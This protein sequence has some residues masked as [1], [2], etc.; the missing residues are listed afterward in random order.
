MSGS[1]NAADAPGFAESGE[2]ASGTS[3]ATPA[4]NFANL[5]GDLA[6]LELRVFGAA[7]SEQ[8][9]IDRLDALERSIFG[10]AQTGSLAGRLA[11]LRTKLNT[12][13]KPSN[14]AP[15]TAG[16]TAGQVA[17][18]GTKIEIA[19]PSAPTKPRL[20][21]GRI[22]EL[23]SGRVPMLPHATTTQTQ[24]GKKLLQSFPNAFKGAW[25]GV[26]QVEQFDYAPSSDPGAV[27]VSQREQGLM[28]RGRLG[29]LQ[30]QFTTDSAGRIRTADSV[31]A[32]QR[33]A[34]DARYLDMVAS[35]G[36]DGE[37]ITRFLVKFGNIQNERNVTGLTINATELSN[38]I[39]QLNANT[40]EQVIETRTDAVDPGSGRTSVNYKE[41]VIRLIESGP[42]QM[43]AQFATVLYGANGA[44]L[45]KEVFHGT[46]TRAG[47][48]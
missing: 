17:A 32:F 24:P 7:M 20:L 31:I 26:A 28:F 33:T 30:V 37:P 19:K 29:Q 5:D 47:A 12:M 3:A 41:S 16:Q 22:E 4:V 34:A 48:R 13:P 40:V 14:A 38:Q 21:N 9:S 15:S 42:N 6:A 46:L 25:T 1:A 23:T 27:A 35:G 11:R 10:E 43:Q 8:P 18:A 2:K 44:Y 36:A 39:T 45:T